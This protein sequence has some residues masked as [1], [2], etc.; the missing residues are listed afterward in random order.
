MFDVLRSMD[1]RSVAAAFGV[2]PARDGIP[3]PCCHEER[4]GDADRRP[5]V[6]FRPD[7]GGWSCHRCGA[8]GDAV[9]LA[10]AIVSGDPKPADWTALRMRVADLG[11]VHEERAIR[12]ASRA[13]AR[14]DAGEL[15]DLWQSGRSDRKSVV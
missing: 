12:P 15:R 2:E 1:C 10:A 4:R 9:A 14:P 5:P 6:G 7:G 3:C 11:L 13:P 8:H